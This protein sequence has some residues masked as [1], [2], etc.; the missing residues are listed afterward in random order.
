MEGTS[1]SASALKFEGISCDACGCGEIVWRRWKCEL[2]NNYDL[3]DDCYMEGEHYQDHPFLLLSKPGNTV[4]RVP[5]RKESGSTPASPITDGGV[6]FD[7]ISCDACGLRDILGV[8]W[9]CEVCTD[10]DLCLACYMAGRHT[11]HPFMRYDWLG[12]RGIMVPPRQPSTDIDAGGML[13]EG[14][15]CD[16]CDERGICGPRWKCLLCYDFD[17][18]GACYMG[19]RHN[20]EHAFLRLNMPGGTATRVPPRKTTART[21]LSYLAPGG[22]RFDN[23][24]CDSCGH[25]SILGA[26]WKCDVCANYDLCAACYLSDV[27]NLDHAFVR[28]DR[29]GGRGIRV[30]PRKQST[31][32]GSKAILHEGIY[33]N[34]CGELGILGKRWKCQ[35][36]IDFDLCT[37]CYMEGKHD[38]KH[39]FLRID[40]AGG[41][42]VRVPPRN[43]NGRPQV[44]SPATEAVSF[45]GII[46][47]GCGQRAFCR[48]A[49]EM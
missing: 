33:C 27:H 47:D 26:R 20:Q 48:G 23:I 43:T 31:D 8:R 13:H 21:Q 41:M 29:P 24:C 35:L 16:A 32:S 40:K 42:A 25:G 4:T 45:D 30:R 7:G 11:T 3:C 2:C 28:F 10:Y 44:S 5:P 34:A 46:C 18:C 37:T 12:H 14:I 36:C 22:V 19:G 49:L 38:Q 6:R 9:K 1:G 17:L 39:P 15:R